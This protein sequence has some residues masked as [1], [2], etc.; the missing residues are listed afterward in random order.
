[1]KHLLLAGLLLTTPADALEQTT[2]A[3]TTPSGMCFANNRWFPAVNGICFM[4]D[5]KP[6]V[7]PRGY[8]NLSASAA[9]TGNIATTGIAQRAPRCQEGYNLVDA[10]RPMCA[11][12][13]IEPE[14]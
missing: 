10:G 3:T 5:F 11:K 13:L 12:D 9:G 4:D 14:W 6:C 1:M 2:A 8:C 7:D